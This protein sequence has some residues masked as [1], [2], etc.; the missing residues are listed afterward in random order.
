MVNCH[1]K[2]NLRLDEWSLREG[3]YSCPSWSARI[4]ARKLSVSSLLKSSKSSEEEINTERWRKPLCS[5]KWMWCDYYILFG[6]QF[7]PTIIFCCPLTNKYIRLL[8]LTL[9]RYYPQ[10]IF[11]LSSNCY[12][13]YTFMNNI[14]SSPAIVCCCPL[15]N[16]YDFY[17]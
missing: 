2:Y 1:V 3:P 5:L 14:P 9:G 17:I 4:S 13:F 12:D 15:Y 6:L 8:Y 7:P 11:F 16:T 10:N